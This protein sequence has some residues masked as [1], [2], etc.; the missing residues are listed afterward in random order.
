MLVPAAALYLAAN[1]VPVPDAEH[2]SATALLIFTWA[3]AAAALS[4]WL[5]RNPGTRAALTGAV[6]LLV[7]AIG[8]VA[9]A[10]VVTGILA[11]DLPAVTMPAASSLGLVAVAVIL[12]A[13]AV[14]RQAPPDGRAG[15]LQ[16]A[17]YAKALVAGHLP[18]PSPQLTP[19]AHPLTR[20]L[21]GA[22][23]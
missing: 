7:A 2:G 22:L 13:L 8:Y 6:A 5:T 11:P 12:G 15:R 1:V 23:Q 14:L 19:T 9:L 16:R 10:R 18:A 21:T 20:Q 17:L 4:A 3:T